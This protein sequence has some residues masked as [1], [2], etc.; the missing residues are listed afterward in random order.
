[1][2]YFVIKKAGCMSS[3]VTLQIVGFQTSLRFLSLHPLKK[4][5]RT[6]SSRE[7]FRELGGV[8]FKK[9]FQAPRTP[10]AREI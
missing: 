6:V 10:C 3:R 7:D 4:M 1:M 5:D 2:P 9:I 8:I